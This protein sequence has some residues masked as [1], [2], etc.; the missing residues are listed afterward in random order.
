M[1][2]PAEEVM[3][4]FI[5]RVL[6]GDNSDYLVVGTKPRFRVYQHRNGFLLLVSRNVLHYLSEKYSVSV[7]ELRIYAI[8]R[9]RVKGV[10]R[11]CRCGNEGG[12]EIIV[13]NKWEQF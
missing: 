5:D 3:N 7:S 2:V 6:S 9:L 1:K 10:G 4:S 11:V 13:F 12:L 8:M